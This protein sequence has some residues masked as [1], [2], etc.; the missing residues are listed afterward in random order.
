MMGLDVDIHPGGNRR[1]Y[2]S[3]VIDDLKKAAISD[4]FANKFSLQAGLFWVDPPL[5]RDGDM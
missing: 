1:Y 3:Y 5:L 2:L 4:D